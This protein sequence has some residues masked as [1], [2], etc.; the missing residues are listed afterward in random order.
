MHASVPKAAVLSRLLVRVLAVLR[1]SKG[2]VIL[3]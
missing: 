2:F 3:I 1:M